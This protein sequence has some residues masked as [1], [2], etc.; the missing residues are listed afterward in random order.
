MLQGNVIEG[1]SVPSYGTIYT[2]TNISGKRIS[3]MQYGLP[4]MEPGD[5]V[6]IPEN[7]LQPAHGALVEDKQLSSSPALPTNLKIL[8]RSIVWQDPT[9]QAMRDE[10]MAS[11]TKLATIAPA[12][13]V[14]DE[15]VVVE[16]Q[17]QDANSII[18]SAHSDAKID[19]ALGAGVIVSIEEGHLISG[20]LNTANAVIGSA[21]GKIKVKVVNDAAG[22]MT[23]DASDA[24][25]VLAAAAQAS[26]AWA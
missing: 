14:V 10:E 1:I 13:G 5:T 26:I 11:A 19:L 22:V 8:A 15:P 25:A 12:N 16:V 21:V 6:D 18:V 9:F 17:V 7:K 3:G 20:A 23:V 2:L 24:D 4:I